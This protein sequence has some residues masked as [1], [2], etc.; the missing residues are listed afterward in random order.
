MKKFNLLFLIV[1]IAG[2]GDSNKAQ[3]VQ[4]C[5]QQYISEEVCGCVYD[6]MKNE[7]G[8]SKKWKNAMIYDQAGFFQVMVKAT[9]KCEDK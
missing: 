2:C 4:G 1:F 9:L 8:E 5:T 6:E 7:L 3:F